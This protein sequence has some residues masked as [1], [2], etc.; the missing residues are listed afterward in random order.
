VSSGSTFSLSKYW[1]YLL[2]IFALIA[3][4]VVIIIIGTRKR[5]K[6]K[7]EPEMDEEYRD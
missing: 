4:N 7:E 3:I 5:N 1:L 2:V 6:I